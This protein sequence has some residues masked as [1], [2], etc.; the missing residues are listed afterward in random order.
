[1]DRVEAGVLRLNLLVK[2]QLELAKKKHSGS[3]DRV[4]AGVLRLNLLVKKQ[5][6]LAKKKLM[7][8]GTRSLQS[9]SKG[10]ETDSKA[11]QTKEA[12]SEV[13]PTAARFHHPV[14][15]DLGISPL[16]HEG[17]TA[18]PMHARDAA[19]PV[20]LTPREDEV[21]PVAPVAPSS[22]R[23][24]GRA[25]EDASDGR[26]QKKRKQEPLP[27]AKVQSESS[28]KLS[29]C[30]KLIQQS[31][32]SRSS[33]E[34]KVEAT[35]SARS[36][37]TGTANSTCDSQ[38]TTG[39]LPRMD[40]AGGVDDPEAAKRLKRSVEDS[41][42][43]VDK[44]RILVEVRTRNLKTRLANEQEK[45]EAAEEKCTALQEQVKTLS[46]KVAELEAQ[47]QTQ[48]SVSGLSPAV[49]WQYEVDDRWEAFAPEANEHMNQA[50][51]KYIRK[52]PGSQYATINSG[53]VA[54]LVDFEERNQKHLTTRKVRQ[55][56]ILPGV[57]S[58]WETSTPNLLQQGNDWQSFYIEV[59]DHAIWNSIR[60]ILQNTGH[61]WD[62]TKDCCCMGWAEIK[63][64]HRIENMRLWHRYKMR[65][66][67]MRQDHAANNILVG[68]AELDLDGYDNIMAQS[69]QTFD[70]GE[71][72]ALVVDE[73]ILLHGT[74]WKNANS[75]VR[76]GF[77]HRT[78]QS[79][80]YGAGVYF[81]CAACKSHQYTC[82]Q[83]KKCCQC[84]CERTLIIARVAL[85]DS[86]VATETRK[87]ERRPPVRPDSSGT[88]DSIVVKPGMINGHH[89]QQQIHQEY[90]IFDREQAYPCYVVQYTAHPK[91]SGIR[92]QVKRL[93]EAVDS[94]LKEYLGAESEAHAVQIEASWAN[95]N[96]ACGLN[97]PHVHPFAALSG[98][99]YVNC[100]N[101]A[102]SRLPCSINLMDP[103]P[104]APMA[105][106]PA[107]ECDATRQFTF[108][109]CE[110]LW[111]SALTGRFH[112]GQGLS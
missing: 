37:G 107:E 86:Y 102:T 71:A 11:K 3:M 16:S 92:K 108:V 61:A 100:G 84:Q 104:S 58:Q 97:G 78:C 30:M 72:L 91:S 89:N 47:L 81:A 79:A 87:T 5:L 40:A 93:R 90:V 27:E 9:D 65:L 62:Q 103:R 33:Q 111:T 13:R 35:D 29:R 14:A 8:T 44:E 80:F 34:V 67:T 55:I 101:N 50:Y 39:Q 70:C 1:M 66:D 109:L 12:T 54:R 74:S 64:V 99:Y 18:R 2:K 23:L 69:Q 57:P 46:E 106:L 22:S 105:A 88:Y 68:S 42:E 85:G 112:C 19:N 56:R 36:T 75:I 63:S 25:Q 26:A 21:A 82:Y 45:R 60:Y 28:R 77:D 41:K 110:M 95:V 31:P 6:E 15:A 17:S 73:K 4:E 32:S 51:L 83:H 53:G 43:L 24:L 98:A 49:T 94:A 48:K 52:I 96:P 10:S 20:V 7:K 59:T 38:L 76:E